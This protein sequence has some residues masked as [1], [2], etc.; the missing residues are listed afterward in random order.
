M[1]TR[2]TSNPTTNPASEI[3]SSNSHAHS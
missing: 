3:S 1:V 2:W